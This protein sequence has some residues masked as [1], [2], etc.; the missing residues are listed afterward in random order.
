MVSES[1]GAAGRQGCRPVPTFAASEAA[2]LL[3]LTLDTRRLPSGMTRNET[4]VKTFDAPNPETRENDSHEIPAD[5]LRVVFGDQ[6]RIADALQVAVRPTPA[7]SE[8]LREALRPI[9]M[10]DHER[11]AERLRAALVPTVAMSD[12]LRRE[13]ARSSRERQEN[14]EAAMGS[15]A[16]IELPKID[17]PAMV[18]STRFPEIDLGEQI[19][20]RVEPL[21]IDFPKPP[22]LP[23]PVLPSHILEVVES[24]NRHVD[25]TMAQTEVTK[26][27]TEAIVALHHAV[28]AQGATGS[29]QGRWIVRLTW[30]L[31]ILSLMVVFL[32]IVIAVLTGI[33]VW[34]GE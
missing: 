26:A 2:A 32:T 5:A 23:P 9:T 1:V 31:V 24:V 10:A 14:L 28:E 18:E 16:R 25:M 8:Q 27:Q 29:E 19:T 22:E 11:V 7:I 33:L 30:A 15:L 6:E 17:W 4:V 34:S 12:D 20:T 3:P 21:E 13:L